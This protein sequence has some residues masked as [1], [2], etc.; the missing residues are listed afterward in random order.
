[1]VFRAKSEEPIKPI[2]NAKAYES[3]LIPSINAGSGKV[4]RQPQNND[5]ED[6]RSEELITAEALQAIKDQAFTEGFEKGRKEGLDSAAQEIDNKTNLLTSLMSE[7]V[8]PLQQC[9]EQT[10]QEL[11]ALAFAISRQ[12]VRRELKQDPTQIVA[13]IRE[14]LKQLPAASKNIQILLH[15]DDASIVREILSIHQNSPDSRWQ[16]VEEPSMERSGCLLKTDNS[17]V[18][19]SVERQIAVLFSRIAGGQRAG[20]DDE[21]E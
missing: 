1:M 18:D 6:Q 4:F 9:G 10:Q 13:I 2:R 12:I 21:T 8:E 7:L 5:A 14:A 11:L 19:A 15:P 3:W 17:K 16:L 20:E